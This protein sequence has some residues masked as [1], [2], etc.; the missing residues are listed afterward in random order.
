LLKQERP[1]Q[2]LVVDDAQLTRRLL[3]LV[4]ESGGY[5]VQTAPSAEEAMRL[6]LQD[7]FDLLVTDLQMR[8]IDGWD[9]VSVVLKRSIL[10][11]TRILVITSEPAGSPVVEKLK[12]LGILVVHKMPSPPTFLGVVRRMLG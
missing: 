4:I 10:P 1:A 12:Q 8:P 9:F 7:R 3:S 2:I 11:T 6:L 5:R